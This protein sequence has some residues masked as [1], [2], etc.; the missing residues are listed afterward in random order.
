MPQKS[1][2]VCG[3][4]EVQLDDGIIRPMTEVELLR[5]KIDETTSDSLESSRRM[6]ALCEEAKEAGISTLVM[7]DDQ[8]E[9]LDRINEG[10]DQINQDMKDAEKNLDDLNKCCG[11]CVLPWNKVKKKDDYTKQLKDE[12]MRGGDGPRIIVDQN[13]MGP[14]GG[15]ITRITNDAREDEMDQNLQEV[16][17]MIGNL[18]NMAI[19]MGSEINQQNVQVERIQIKAKSNAERIKKANEQASKLLK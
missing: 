4:D 18:R 5:R 10:M 15:Y 3:Y 7:L 11:L 14:T 6:M 2:P 9:Q 19:D 1:H 17:G 12:D 13:G 8:G 16:S